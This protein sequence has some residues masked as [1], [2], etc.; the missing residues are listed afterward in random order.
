MGGEIQNTLFPY[1]VYRLLLIAYPSFLFPLTSSI[2]RLSLN[3]NLSLSGQPQHL[4]F[5][6]APKLD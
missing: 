4:Y 6:A 2:F 3:L 1:P 5:A